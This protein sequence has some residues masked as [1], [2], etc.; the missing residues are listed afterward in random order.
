MSE[1]TFSILQNSDLAPLLGGARFPNNQGQS[2]RNEC[3]ELQVHMQAADLSQASINACLEAIERLQWAFDRFNVQP[4]NQEG[5]EEGED[6]SELIFSWPITITAE[7][8]ELLLQR[9]PEALAVL[10]HYAVLLYWKRDMWVIGD[11]GRWLIESITR[12]LGAFWSKW[13]SLP[14]AV[15]QDSST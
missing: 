14:L 8:T 12:Y 9:K 10:A 15:L 4:R 11:G 2:G 5:G 13:L 7:F 3:A 1:G 6:N